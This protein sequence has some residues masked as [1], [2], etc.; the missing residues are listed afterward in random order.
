MG[1]NTGS[2]DDV[3]KSPYSMEFYDSSW[4]LEYM[5]EL[6]NDKT[7]SKWTKNHGIRISYFTEDHKFKTYNPDFLVEYTNGDIELVEMKGT[8]LLNNPNT[9][10]KMDFA[11]KWCSSRKIKYRIYSKYQ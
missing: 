7:V 11:K 1:I 9:R 8:H 4:E 3:V 2:I 10:I 6:E 5:K